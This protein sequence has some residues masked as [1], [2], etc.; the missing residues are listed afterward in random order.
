MPSRIEKYNVSN[1]R[2][3]DI[4][5]TEKIFY[6]KRLE[7][8]ERGLIRSNEQDEDGTVVVNISGFLWARMNGIAQ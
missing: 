2:R 6:K 3:A 1:L 7:A 4:T 5:M 8:D